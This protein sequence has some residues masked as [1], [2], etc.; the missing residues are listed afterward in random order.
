MVMKNIL[1]AVDLH[2]NDQALIA[3]A[4]TLAEKFQSKIWF[5]HVAAPDP[6]FVGYEVG[7]TYIRDTRAD[8]LRREH[9]LL[10]SYAAQVNAQTIETDALLIQGPTIEMLRNEVV[11]L[12]IDLLILGGHKHSFLYEAFIGHTATRIIKDVSIPVLIIPLPGE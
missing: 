1:V 8:Q 11:K 4:V 3:W 12:N 2:D 7:P 10:Q 5:I 9:R 6:D